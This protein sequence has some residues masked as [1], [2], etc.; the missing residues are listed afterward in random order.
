M[1]INLVDDWYLGIYIDAIQWVQLPNTRG[2]SHGG[3]Q[4]RV[5]IARAI[6]NNPKYL[7][8]DEPNSGL[9]PKTAIVIDNLIQEITRE[10]NIVTVI[11]SHDMNSVMEIGE[12]II[13]LKDGEKAWEGSK[14]T[15]FKTDNE[16]VSNFV[17][18]SNLFKKVREM[19]LKG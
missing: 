10:Y 19:Y 12:K 17:Y 18:S 8:C 4:K 5:A 11:N 13:F 7:F 2:M 6:V 15:I 1:R 14:D 3:M 16:A 9:D